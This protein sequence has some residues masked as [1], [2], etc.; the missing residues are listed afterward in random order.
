VKDTGGRTATNYAEDQKK[1]E[2]V[3]LLKQYTPAQS[4]GKQ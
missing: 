1:D 2:I 3:R 4:A